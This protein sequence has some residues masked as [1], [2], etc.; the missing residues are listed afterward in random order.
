[1]ADCIA[2]GRQSKG[3]RHFS[4]KLTAQRV[5]AARQRYAEGGISRRTLAAIYGVG[6]TTMQS[7]LERKTWREAA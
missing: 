7:V 5:V 4:A 3:D 2:K 6:S 1:M